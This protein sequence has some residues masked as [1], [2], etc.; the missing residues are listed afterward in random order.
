VGA[1]PVLIVLTAAA[2]LLPVLAVVAYVRG[3]RALPLVVIGAGAWLLSSLSAIRTQVV[4]AAARS[5]AVEEAATVIVARAP[6]RVGSA[7]QDA[8]MSRLLR[9]I[10]ARVRRAGETG[11]TI[12]GSLVAIPIA[13]AVIAVA[14][15]AQ[16]PLAAFAAGA[17]GVLVRVPLARRHRTALDELSACHVALSSDLGR[18]IRALED[19]RAHGLES[20]FLSHHLEL[21]RA[22]AVAEARASRASLAATWIPLGAAGAALGGILL[23][24]LL[25]PRPE[26]VV[27]LVTLAT[28]APMTVAL[29]RS[30]ATDAAYARDVLPL[31]RLVARSPD[32]PV[33]PVYAAPPE[34]L[35]P[36]SLEAVR[37]RF[38]PPLPEVGGEGTTT[39]GPWILDQI[40]LRWSGEKPLVLVGPNG[41]GKSTLLAILLRLD[42][43]AEGAVT[44][45]GVDARTL[46]PAAWRARIAFVPQ[47][48]LV[49]G[50]ASVADTL[51]MVAPE[52][53][54]ARLEV[55][56]RETGLWDRLA[57]RGDPLRVSAHA[58]SVGESRRLALARAL[59]RDAELW[60]LDE[61]EAG[62]DPEGRKALRALL[63]RQAARGVRLVLAVQHVEVAPEG[64]TIIELP[65]PPGSTVDC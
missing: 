45:G 57:R 53:D 52:A 21:A 23:R 37:Y 50:D 38:L 15:G 63:E 30:W 44:F 26:A 58:L 13:L 10:F 17:V 51:R 27:L 1:D 19:L 62:L 29:A 33:P 56:L 25:G 40:T 12:A 36:V 5:R 20:K 9:A 18:G 4:Q 2:R 35:C 8:W 16:V 32:L 7:H 47:R 3:A 39:E 61:P 31:D 49:L 43:P 64:G 34:S 11:P 55:A 6:T 41:S 24:S 46:D 14:R 54:D 59:I 48:P 42:D 60:V 65:R 22:V 28:L